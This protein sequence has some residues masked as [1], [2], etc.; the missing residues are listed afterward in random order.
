MLL[1]TILNSEKIIRLKKFSQSLNDLFAL[2]K[3]RILHF[4]NL[5]SNKTNSGI[6]R[7]MYKNL[8]I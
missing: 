3:C 2:M 4:E 6:K 5:T 8:I 7:L 1:Y